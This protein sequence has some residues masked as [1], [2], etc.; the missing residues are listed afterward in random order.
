MSGYGSE[1]E[2][3]TFNPQPEQDVSDNED[4]A[5]ATVEPGEDGDPV[6]DDDNNDEENEDDD[7]DEDE[8]EDDD[9][10]DVRPHKR[11]KKARRNM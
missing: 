6:P 9:E 5:A 10:E 4:Q 8:E 11:R 7:E 1:S 3:E 2:E